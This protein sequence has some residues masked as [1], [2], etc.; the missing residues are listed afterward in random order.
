MYLSRPYHL[1][2][3]LS[4]II[5]FLLLSI[6][7]LRSQAAKDNQFACGQDFFEV[8]GLCYHISPYFDVWDNAERYCSFLGA[9]LTNFLPISS[10]L[11]EF[12]NKLK[13]KWFWRG[14]MPSE[15]KT[16]RQCTV[17]KADPVKIEMMDCASR[18]PYLCQR[19][20]WTFIGS[21][22]EGFFGAGDDCFRV[23][24]SV[25][26]RVSANMAS[27]RCQRLGGRLAEMNATGQLAAIRS[28]MEGRADVDVVIKLSK[29]MEYAQWPRLQKSENY[30]V[31]GQYSVLPGSISVA[32]PENAYGYV[33]HA[34]RV[35]SKEKSISRGTFSGE[36][37]SDGCIQ[38]FASFSRDSNLCVSLQTEAKSWGDARRVCQALRSDLVSIASEFELANVLLQRV[39][40]R[41]DLWLGLKDQKW[42]DG[43]HSAFSYFPSNVGVKGCLLMNISGGL[44]PQNCSL[45][46]PFLCASRK[47]SAPKIVDV[48]RKCA[49]Q[50][51][52][53]VQFHGFCYD[54]VLMKKNLD[55]AKKYCSDKFKYESLMVSVKQQ[56][57]QYKERTTLGFLLGDVQTKLEVG[58]SKE[59][60]FLLQ[61]MLR[62]LDNNIIFPGLWI[63]ETSDYLGRPTKRGNCGV[64]PQTCTV[65][66]MD[67][68]WS[69]RCCNEHFYFI[70][71]TPTVPS[72]LKLDK[73]HNT[74]I[75]TY[76]KATIICIVVLVILV[77]VVG[78]S[79]FIYKRRISLPIPP[80]T[81]SRS[82]AE[83]THSP[84]TMSQL[85]EHPSSEGIMDDVYEEMDSPDEDVE[86]P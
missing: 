31:L 53:L 14:E 69:K 61:V 73:E 19:D 11:R 59:L 38:G 6:P 26:D 72:G 83:D 34:K 5:L 41:N 24:S 17:I 30:R 64:G 84:K 22:P 68:E 28:N 65:S 76:F 66:L 50:N 8:G 51:A 75:K 78:V 23:F 4:L 33:C 9:K 3:H 37:R 12:Q 27:N 35:V 82:N 48:T 74:S 32:Q 36:W 20:L 71:K 49:F 55:S 13:K 85:L 42:I 1:G 67:G 77:V 15:S 2:S 80:K 60:A 52:S 44:R 29:Y 18:L 63:I 47:R 81:D 25:L 70:C 43:T 58:M 21:C 56:V 39:M 40:I 7:N 62:R 79:W 16:F 45:R 57:D 10:K 86:E 46:L 54:V